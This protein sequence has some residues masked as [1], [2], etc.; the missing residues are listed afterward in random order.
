MTE[1]IYMRYWTPCFIVRIVSDSVNRYWRSST[2]AFGFYHKHIAKLKWKPKEEAQ[3]DLDA[4]AKE[5]GLQEAGIKKPYNLAKSE[6]G[7]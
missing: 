2:N 3:A 1:T 4:I 7:E 5:L 6:K